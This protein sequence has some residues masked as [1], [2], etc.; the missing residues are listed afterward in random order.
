MLTSFHWFVPK[1]RCTGGSLLWCFRSNKDRRGSYIQL[2]VYMWKENFSVKGK[3]STPPCHLF[4]CLKSLPSCNSFRNV[5]QF[6]TPIASHHFWKKISAGF[7]QNHHC[8]KH[9]LP[10]YPD[11]KPKPNWLIIHSLHSYS[12]SLVIENNVSS[13]GFI[14]S[15]ISTPVESFLSFCIAFHSYLG[16][17]LFS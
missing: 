7:Q 16:I 10:I 5:P 2:I 1:P 4:E 8:S 14:L 15:F 17:C 3:L 6:S 12:S 9:H 11:P 13:I